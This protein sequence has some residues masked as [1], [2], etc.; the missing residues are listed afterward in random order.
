MYSKNKSSAV[1]TWSTKPRLCSLCEIPNA[2]VN[3][4]LIREALNKNFSN[5]SANSRFQKHIH[6]NPLQLKFH[7]F[8]F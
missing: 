8:Q 4:Q 5:L 3:V 6:L 1:K 7:Y 2:Q